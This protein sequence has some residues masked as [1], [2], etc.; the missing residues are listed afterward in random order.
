MHI[1][2]ASRESAVRPADSRTRAVGIRIRATA[3]IRTRSSGS[4]GGMCSSGVPGEGTRAL[5]GTLSGWGSRLARVRSI[6][7]RSSTLSPMPM[8]PPEQTVT[9][10]L[11]TFSRVRRRSSK[12]RV[13]MI[14]R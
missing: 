4:T 11:R 12:V 14:E 1:S 3:I 9:P 10:A 6:S 8:I 13:L 7:Q 2:C 5:I